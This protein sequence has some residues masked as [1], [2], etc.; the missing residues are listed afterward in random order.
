LF[1]PRYCF[2]LG[3]SCTSSVD[4][5][6]LVGFW[7]LVA[8]FTLLQ[9][10]IGS[11]GVAYYVYLSMVVFSWLLLCYGLAIVMCSMLLEVRVRLHPIFRL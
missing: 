7:K 5:H 9:A 6:D 1:Y 4:H 8:L 11:H 2:L 10:A 3:L